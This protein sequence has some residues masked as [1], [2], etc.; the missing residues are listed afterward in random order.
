MET[1]LDRLL[2][3][4]SAFCS[5]IEAKSYSRVVSQSSSRPSLMHLVNQ[6]WKS[7]A[8]RL[9]SFGPHPAFLI[10]E[11]SSEEASDEESGFP[12][13][14]QVTESILDSQHTAITV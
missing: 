14:R 11:G 8:H 7:V 10:E 3:Q 4:A 2:D 5:P 13:I 1:D 9:S 12:S 6:N